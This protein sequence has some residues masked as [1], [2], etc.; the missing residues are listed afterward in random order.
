M[1][2]SEIHHRKEA[3]VLVGFV[4]RESCEWTVL[5]SGIGGD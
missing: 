4:S 2:G 5:L 3:N 1:R